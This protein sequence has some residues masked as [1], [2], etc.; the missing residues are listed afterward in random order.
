MTGYISKNTPNQI[1][2]SSFLLNNIRG[3]QNNSQMKPIC[4]Q[5]E[6]SGETI[7]KTPLDGIVL[8][9]L[10]INTDVFENIRNIYLN[11]IKIKDTIEF[12]FDGV[13]TSLM[14][15]PSEC[16]LNEDIEFGQSFAM[17]NLN[18]KMCTFGT[19]F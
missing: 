13:Q 9:F 4:I 7:L 11:P 5:I 16:T 8:N 15:Q 18:L 6:Y 12:K 17:T 10:D 3:V 1:Q 2:K 19:H 14:N